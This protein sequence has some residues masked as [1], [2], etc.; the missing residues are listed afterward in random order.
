MFVYHISTRIKPSVL[1]ELNF[2]VKVAKNQ[3]F[4]LNIIQVKNN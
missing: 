2:K 4:L 3:I 1:L